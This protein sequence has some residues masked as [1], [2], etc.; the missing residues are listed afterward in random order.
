MTNAKTTATEHAELP[1]RIPYSIGAQALGVDD[2]AWRTLVD[3]VF[4][5]AKTQAGVILALNY[6]KRR[7]LDVFKRPVHIVPMNTKKRSP[8]GKEYWTLIETVWPGINELRT[9]AFRTG[10]YAGCDPAQ[11][12]P[13]L[14]QEWEFAGND[15]AGEH[16]NA[17]SAGEKKIAPK[18]TLK[19]TIPEWCQITVYRMIAG[20]R[21]PFPGPRVYW[22]EAYA[23]A[24][25]SELPNEMWRDRARG[26]IEKCAEAAALRK[27]FPEELAGEYTIDEA[28]R[29]LDVTPQQAIPDDA[30]PDRSEIEAPKSQP[31]SA[32]KSAPKAVEHAPAIVISESLEHALAT[33][34]KLDAAEIAGGRESLKQSLPADEYAAWNTAALQREKTLARN[35][36]R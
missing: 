12:G 7:G 11:F 26:Q 6:C 13:D 18:R 29:M 8:D 34:P 36:R 24:G 1:A 17:P 16:P 20:Q 27:A 28:P 5:S 2:A 10:V 22:L 4:P 19:L 23:T 33:L 32:R 9:T 30:R 31:E 3:A 35:D 25:R 14:I 21:V 15:D